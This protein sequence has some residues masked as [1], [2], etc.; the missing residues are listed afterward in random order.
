MEK[1]IVIFTFILLVFLSLNFADNPP[2]EPVIK[3][4][5]TSTT[6]TICVDNVC[7]TQLFQEPTFVKDTDGTFKEYTSVR[8][9]KGTRFK[10]DIFK[11]LS[12]DADVTCIDYNAT[13]MRIN[14]TF[15]ETGDIPIKQYV[16]GTEFLSQRQTV[17]IKP[18]QLEKPFVYDINFAEGTVLHIGASSTI[19]KLTA[20]DTGT[21]Y[22]CDYMKSSEATATNWGGSNTV[23]SGIDSAG[24]FFFACK[25]NISYLPTGVLIRNANMTFTFIDKANLEAGENVNVQAYRI[26]NNFTIGGSEWTSGSG[27]GGLG[28]ATDMA[29]IRRPSESYLLKSRVSNYTFYQADATNTQYVFKNLT[30][31]INSEWSANNKDFSLW[32]NFTTGQL[33]AGTSDYLGLATEEHATVAYRPYLLIE[34]DYN[35]KLNITSP[36]TESA[37]S[38]TPSKNIT[39]TLNATNSGSAITSGLKFFNATVDTELITSRKNR[40]CEG[41][42]N[43][44]STYNMNSTK[45]TASGCTSGTA[46]LNFSQVYKRQFNTTNTSFP[47]VLNMTW[48]APTGSKWLVITSGILS[49]NDTARY[50]QVIVNKNSVNQ[51]RYEDS[52]LVA[53]TDVM[54]FTTMQIATG[55]NA[56]IHYNILL[57][58]STSSRAFIEDAMITRIRIDN[59]PNTHYTANESLGET[60][61]LDNVFGDDVGDTY[62]VSFTP[63][64]AG[65]YLVY[66]TSSLESDITSSSVS[67]R[68]NIDNGREYIPYLTTGDATYSYGRIED[69]A[70]T[71][72]QY[73]GAMAVRYFNSTQEHK[74][75]IQGA[76]IDVTASADWTFNSV[77][78]VR[79][80]GVFDTYYNSTSATE[81]TTASTSF[82]NKTNIDITSAG[83]YLILGSMAIRGDTATVDFE[84]KMALNNGGT[85]LMAWRPKDILDYIPMVFARNQTYTS[86][87][88]SVAMQYRRQDASGNALAK[89]GDI[90]AIKLANPSCSGSPSAC[91]TYTTSPTC[92]NYGCSWN[93]NTQFVHTANGIWKVNLT[94]PATSYSGL[95]DLKMYVNLSNT[96]F[97]NNEADC[98]DYGGAG[99]TCVYDGSGNYVIDSELCTLSN[100]TN[101][102][103]GNFLIIKGTSCALTVKDKVLTIGGRNLS[104]NCYFNVSG[105][106]QIKF[107]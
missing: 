52:V 59:L 83:N 85:S 43:V 45:C 30:G 14:V 33:D 35:G 87:T 94:L 97:G 101:I 70:T 106:G 32:F 1:K 26:F 38:V 41:T 29:Y 91:S 9:L 28:G 60:A 17:N 72:R 95:H 13:W 89:N 42:P 57:A 40:F 82:Q 3:E 75:K 61:N 47:N 77:L 73:F 20:N 96:V 51:F 24:N 39:I 56:N 44:C 84:N 99:S 19:I 34:Y 80:T 48:Y 76:D 100:N 92:S 50:A 81:A 103:A 66:G 2:K 31:A 46:N 21:Q 18:N 10:C 54:P 105:T 53:R 49:I 12:L 63:P 15:H 68:L 102:G 55:A 11:N 23:Y 90:L 98:L 7:K 37:L 69:R 71:E 74:V 79:L 104:Q 64:T 107:I 78:A 36:T 93:T 62:T 22:G 6:K 65:W 4:T 58:P 8:S 16:G 27:T 86:G 5:Y 67:W 25:W 88:N